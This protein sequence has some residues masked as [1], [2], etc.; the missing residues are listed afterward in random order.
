MEAV[1]SFKQ[2]LDTGEV[3]QS[4]HLHKLQGAGDVWAISWGTDN[5]GR[6]TFSYGD[7]VEP[8][9]PHI[10]WRRVGTHKIYGSP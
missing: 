2:G 8:G 9:E 4:L 1:D 6:A 7:A 10:I 3:P 5:D